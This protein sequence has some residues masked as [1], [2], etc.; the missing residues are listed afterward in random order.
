MLARSQFSAGDY[1]D[2]ITTIRRALTSAELPRR[3]AGTDSGRAG[4][5]PADC[6]RRPRPSGRDRPPGPRRRRGGR[7]RLRGG[8]RPGRTVAE[9][10]RQAR[11]CR[12]AR[13]HRPG[14]ARAR[15][16]SRPPGDSL[17]TSSTSNEPRCATASS[18]CRT[19]TAGRKPSWRSG[20]PASSPSGPGALIAQHGLT[21]RCCGTGSAS[22]TT[23]WPSSAPTTP[24]R[25]PYLR[26]RWPALLVHGVAALIAGRRE[27]RTTAGEHLRQGLALPIE[28]RADRENQDFLRRRARA[29]AGTER[30][31]R[32]GHA[33]AGCDI[34]TPRR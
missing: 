30:R 27:Q 21:R 15:R 12:R 28:S 16:R 7:R 4:A 2:A 1:E 34:A 5:A 14:A 9:P 10:E 25:T 31:D 23:R 8:A 11:P 3:V 24:I 17:C 26:E 22:G 33:E 18:R 13:L 29:G 19:S 20:R 32:A 6:H